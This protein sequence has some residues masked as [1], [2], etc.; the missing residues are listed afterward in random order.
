MRIVDLFSG[1]GGL[2]FGFYY[3]LVNDKFVKRAN[4][5]FVFANEFAPQAVAAFRKNYG[6]DI[7]MIAG[8]ICGITDEEIEKRLNGEEVDI[9]IGGPPC[10]SFSTVGQRK[11]DERAKLSN[12]YLR[13]LDKIKPKM[14]LFENVKGILSM[15]EIFYETDENGE[16]V[17][18][19]VEKHRGTK[20]FI[21]KEQIGRAHV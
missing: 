10:Q 5:E 20:T 4:V 16:P 6:D 2:T 15:R 13:L 9:I 14:F 12:Q 17:Y 1:A 3:N 18:K 8:D 19:E 7:P 21:K 11:Y